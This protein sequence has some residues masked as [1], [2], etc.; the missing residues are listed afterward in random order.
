MAK[1]NR[2]QAQ[3]DPSSGGIRI[4]YEGS[5]SIGH[6]VFALHGQRAIL[7]AFG[8]AGYKTEQ[9]AI[10]ALLASQEVFQIYKA[11]HE[12]AVIGTWY[13]MCLDGDKDFG[14]HT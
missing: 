9:A 11:A 2:V 5:L 3:L 6:Q 12:G 8:A 14:G 7:D 1:Q 4:D 10:R 13:K